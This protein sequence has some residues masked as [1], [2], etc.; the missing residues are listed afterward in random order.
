[1][2]GAPEAGRK[3]LTA[4]LVSSTVG[5]TVSGSTVSEQAAAESRTPI[6]KPDRSQLKRITGESSKSRVCPVQRCANQV[7]VGV[8]NRFGSV[9]HSGSAAF[10][11]HHPRIAH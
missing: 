1:M 10:P 11:P 7:Q 2:A 8:R 4:K 5:A 6:E 9:R 3:K